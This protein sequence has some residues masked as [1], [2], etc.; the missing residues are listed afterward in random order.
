MR[1]LIL[2]LFIACIT[3]CS[4][5]NE[6][7][8]EYILEEQEYVQ[9]ESSQEEFEYSDEEYKLMFDFV[10]SIWVSDL[11]GISEPTSDLTYADLMNIS[12]SVIMTDTFGDTLGEGDCYKVY[13]AMYK[14]YSDIY[15][16][17]KVY[18]Y[19]KYI[20]ENDLY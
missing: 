12:A 5:D 20:L 11:F 10:K 15:P 18:R 16:E 3:S 9:E 17:T 8:E 4:T 2:I 19:L 14:Y 13:I 1:N 7:F 6:Y